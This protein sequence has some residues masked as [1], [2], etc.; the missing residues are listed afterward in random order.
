MNFYVYFHR[1]ND[2]GEVFYI[3]KGC[4]KRA[5]KKSTRS[6]WWKRI[7]AKHGRTVEIFAEGLSENDAF[8]LESEQIRA[9]GI[10]NLCNLRE[11]GLGGV[12]PSDETRKKMSESHKGRVVSLETREKNRIA[13]T[14]RKHSQ[15]TKDK[16]REIN[17]GR[18]G[19]RHSKETKEKISA[20]KKGVKFSK[21]HCERIS[22]SKKGVRGHRMSEKLKA[23]MASIHTGRKHSDESK[24]KMSE[25][26][27]GKRHSAKTIEAMTEHNRRNNALRRKPV[28]CGNGMIFEY[29]GHAEAWLRDNGFPAANRSNISSCCTGKLKT[30][31]GFTWQFA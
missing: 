12:S 23:I 16:L 10:G 27:T 13:S 7:E 9:H 26:S 21:E 22:L 5:W 18:E 2:T 25:S 8:L 24:K 3:G 14:G 1:R 20:K 11:G 30:A 4:G 19:F 31:Y 6:E 28:S 17:L 29:S 15:E